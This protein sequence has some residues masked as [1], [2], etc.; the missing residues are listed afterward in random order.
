MAADMNLPNIQASDPGVSSSPIVNHIQ[1]NISFKD[2][3][4]Y[5]D[6]TRSTMTTFVLANYAKYHVTVSWQFQN[7]EIE[8]RGLYGSFPLV[9]IRPLMEGSIWFSHLTIVIF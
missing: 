3:M 2:Y 4:E 9:T 5:N 6:S 1:V 7:K 8:L